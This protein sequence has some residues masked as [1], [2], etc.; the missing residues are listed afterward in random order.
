MLVNIYIYFVYCLEK[1]FE[2]DPFI[3]IFNFIFSLF[4]WP[5]L[6]INKK[7]LLLFHILYK[8]FTEHISKELF[9]IHDKVLLFGIVKIQTFKEN[10]FQFSSIS[11]ICYCKPDNLLVFI[12]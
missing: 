8:N 11:K 5:K 3:K 6:Y 1:K 7:Y 2:L 4:L 12:V 9:E 10:R